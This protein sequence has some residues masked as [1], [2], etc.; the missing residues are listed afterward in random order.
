MAGPNDEAI[1]VPLESGA[2]RAEYD[3]ELAT[4]LRRRLGYLCIAYVVF[5]ILS[6]GTLVAYSMGIIGRAE[7]E[8]AP[9][10]I[11][12]RA[13]QAERRADAGLAPR[14]GDERAKAIAA[15]IRERE[16]IARQRERSREAVVST[17]DV[18]STVVKD[19]ARGVAGSGRERRR[20]AP[21]APMRP[22]DRWY[23]EESGRA[24]VATPADKPS[25]DD[26]S[27]DSGQSGGSA[28]DGAPNDDSA[29]SSG[30]AADT[31][32][33]GD[34]LAPTA[35]LPWWTFLALG[36]P[37]LL[38]V[39]WFGLLVRPKLLTRAELVAAASRMILILGLINFIFEAALLIAIPTIPASPLVSIFFWHFTASL[40]LP[41]SWRESLKPIAPLLACWLLLS[42]GLAV[43]Q[44]SWSVLGVKVLAL[45]FIFAPA[46]V[47]CYFRLRWHED[48][49]KTGFVGR[50]F[51]EMR[52]EYQQARAVH[53]SL[54]PKPFTTEW[55][56]F[57]F[58]YRP[59]AEI[60]GDFI[61][62]WIGPD[63]R[64]Y[65]T[66]IDVTGHGLASAMSVARIHGEIERLRDEHP[67]EGPAKL[68]ARLNRY[69]HRL[70][71]RHRLYATGLLLTI[72]PRT[73]EMRYASAGHPPIFHRSKGQV[74]ELAS[75]TFMLGAVDNDVFGE[76]EVTI[77]LEERDTLILFT[78]GAYDAKNPRGERFGM[79]QLRDTIARPIAPPKWTQFLMR[80]LETFEAGVAED[81][82]L[83]AEITLLQRSDAPGMRAETMPSSWLATTPGFDE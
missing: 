60:G 55:M 73:G 35:A 12:R 65:L 62:A 2:I 14:P 78:D 10:P 45:P 28:A 4:W 17:L 36:G 15:E 38:V 69:F 82:L 67:D 37:Y 26:E 23:L 32:G 8:R 58:G 39:A 21:A 63:G 22:A 33:G 53:E 66:L 41:W 79:E 43:A 81:D 44:E 16:E 7:T 9:T 6:T 25:L 70:L 56:R 68:L 50:R 24:G 64:F 13:E 30:D 46:L 72:D 42:M 1:D 5:Q 18:L 3:R 49:F 48:K 76:D 31:A 19:A 27:G 40:F 29:A 74:T 59:A 80:L 51:L 71:A 52:R 83:I 20:P 54:F 75:T 61:H 11:E 77:Q 47:L 34:A 57:D